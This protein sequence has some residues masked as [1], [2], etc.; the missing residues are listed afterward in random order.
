V[1]VQGCLLA[2]I[3]YNT[4]I[5]KENL[6]PSLKGS[7]VAAIQVNQIDDTYH[8]PGKENAWRQIQ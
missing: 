8:L 6:F 7:K 5:F 3:V 1:S 2:G 4:T